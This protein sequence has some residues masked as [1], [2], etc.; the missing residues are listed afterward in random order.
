MSQGMTWAAIASAMLAA[1]ALAC[2]LCAYMLWRQDK[3]GSV[4]TLVIVGLGTAAVHL[5]ANAPGV[6]DPRALWLVAAVRNLVWL[7]LLRA[8][9]AADGRH[10]SVR[11]VR[12]VIAALALV[13]LLQF[14]LVML[15]ELFVFPGAFELVARVSSIFQLLF[16]TGML[17]L[18]H[19]LFIG[20]APQQRGRMGWMA[21]A[22]V[23]AWGVELNAYAIMYLAGTLP[24]PVLAVRA[25]A[26]TGVA[27]ML[28]VDGRQKSARTF[29]PSRTVTFQSLSLLVIALYLFAL[30]TIDSA[31][32]SSD[33]ALGTVS[34]FSAVVLAVFV[35]A[36]LAST[37]F[38]AWLRETVA[39]NLFRHRYDYREE[40]LRLTRTIAG[41][42]QDLVPLEQRA[43]QALA[44]IVD[45]PAGLLLT[46]EDDGLVA[47]SARWCWPSLEVPPS[48]LPAAMLDRFEQTNAVVILD[49][50]RSGEGH[51]VDRGLVP[52]WLLAARAAWAMVPLQV[53]A[54]LAGVVVLARPAYARKL[55]WEDYDLLR[56]VGQQLAVHLSENRAQKALLDAARFD[57]FNRRMAFVM[58]DIK[59]LASQFGLL[60]SNAERHIEKPAFRADMLVTLRNAT[61]RLETLLGRLSNYGAQ[62]SG[63]IR[64]ITAASAVK[65]ALA[66]EI[67]AGLVRVG[68]GG[69]SLLSGDPEALEQV[70]R[71]LVRNGIEASANGAPVEISF[72]GTDRDAGIEIADKGC[73]MSPEFVRSTLFKPFVST[74][75]DG[76]G[77]GAFEAREL[78]RAMGGRLEVESR[79]GIGSRFVVWLPRASGES[80]ETQVSRK[81]A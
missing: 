20:A 22:L 46:P 42:P 24:A 11:P 5:L 65:E 55:D 12:P 56:I 63:V 8:L 32:A 31:L 9:F 57:E 67:G 44:D 37:G 6:L 72:P 71:H 52:E 50:L 26:W 25:L 81:V 40:W 30:F 77:I 41:V 34:R 76:F 68:P 61:H 39:R 13:E 27:A 29:S 10:T 43:V 49:T 18:I 62:G 7:A 4:R 74:K 48:P 70:M 2:L 75:T 15:A 35:A 73:G 47:L 16:V 51:P 36:L 21:G 14:P 1:G 33:F 69:G 23:L 66:V 38:R 54:K 28:W 45:S 17:V 80:G 64:A 60:V 59:N 58:H 19:N 53:D 79:V 3:P 78:V